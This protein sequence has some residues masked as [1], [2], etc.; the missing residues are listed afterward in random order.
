[1]Y[2]P[3]FLDDFGATP[4]RMFNTLHHSHQGNIVTRRGSGGARFRPRARPPAIRTAPF[5]ILVLLLCIAFD[6]L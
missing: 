6:F 4:L 1:M 2:H 3:A 5:F